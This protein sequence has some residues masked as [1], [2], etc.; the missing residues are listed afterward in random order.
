MLN[1]PTSAA[2]TFVV[3]LPGSG[4]TH[5]LRINESN[6]E[7]VF[8]DFHANAFE[9]SHLFQ[10]AQRFPELLVKLNEGYHCYV[11]DIAY[12]LQNR[13]QEAEAYLIN[14][15]PSLSIFW[16]FFAN[17]PEKCKANVKLDKN[18]EVAKRLRKI[19]E[20]TT[21]YTIPVDVRPIDIFD[22][23]RCT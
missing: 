8:D 19:D 3:G 15:I 11:A 7:L 20:F 16:I 4:K 23:A 14:I 17:E 2:V 10:C 13:R 22:G 6:P 21:D 9:N 1:S 5:W 18:R 12:C